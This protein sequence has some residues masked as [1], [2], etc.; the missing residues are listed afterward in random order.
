MEKEEEKK[1][2]QERKK[3]K[4]DCKYLTIVHMML[5]CNETSDFSLKIDFCTLILSGTE[6]NIF[7]ACN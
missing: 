4:K 5:E 2:V 6:R 1:E 3:W 7:L